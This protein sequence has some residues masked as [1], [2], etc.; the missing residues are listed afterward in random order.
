MK[1][2][3]SSSVHV[4]LQPTYLLILLALLKDYNWEMPF[5]FN[6]VGGYEFGQGKRTMTPYADSFE[7]NYT[8]L[9][10]GVQ[11]WARLLTDFALP[12]NRWCRQ[13]SLKV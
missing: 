8:A 11:L 3:N 9:R 5:G 6:L 7:G 10:G 1:I 12:L 4:E 2:Q 13:L